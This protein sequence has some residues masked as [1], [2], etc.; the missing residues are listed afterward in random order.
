MLVYMY[1]DHI[2]L[3]MLH[4]RV[5]C[6]HGNLECSDMSSRYEIHIA[7]ALK[8]ILKSL[9][10]LLSVHYNLQVIKEGIGEL[11]L[12]QR[13]KEN[14]KRTYGLWDFLPC[15][16]CLGFYL[17]SSLWIHVRTCP[18]KPEKEC[19]N[20]YVRNGRALLTPILHCIG[21]DDDFNLDKL[22]LS[23]KETRKN[24]GIPDICRN[25]EIIREFAWGQL[26]RLGTSDEK[27]L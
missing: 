7:N 25:D 27:R 14:S 18:L 4:H 3:S 6:T 2:L 8:Y 1:F 9:K 5:S 19:E 10:F 22:F 23:M 24:P 26:E 16:Y 13:P 20:N 15:E 17:K 11:V 12:V 21:S